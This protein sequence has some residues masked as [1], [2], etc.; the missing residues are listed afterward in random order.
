MVGDSLS[1]VVW[2]GEMKF[3]TQMMA[4]DL[5]LRHNLA[6]DCSYEADWWSSCC[7]SELYL[8]SGETLHWQQLQSLVSAVCPDLELV[9]LGCLDILL[10]EVMCGSCW[11]GR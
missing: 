4:C 7:W 1:A 10:V 11:V 5:E 3:L 8:V 9:C 6:Q 2:G